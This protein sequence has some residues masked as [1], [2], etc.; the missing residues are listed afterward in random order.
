M[1]DINNFGDSYVVNIK[2]NKNYEL[3]NIK[4]GPTNKRT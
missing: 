3:L 2:E 1:F 4:M